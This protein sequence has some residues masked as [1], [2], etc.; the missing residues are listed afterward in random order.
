MHIFD[1]V[2]SSA[3]IPAALSTRHF[4]GRRAAY[5]TTQS[6][7]EECFQNGCDLADVSPFALKGRVVT[8]E[9]RDN[10]SKESMELFARLIGG[11]Y[12]G[13]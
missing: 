9:R 8:L 12:A 5:F 3:N 1:H 6:H 2:S 11:E 4:N 7:M 10:D 13:T